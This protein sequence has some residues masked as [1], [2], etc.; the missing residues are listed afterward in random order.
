METTNAQEPLSLQDIFNAVWTGLKAQSWI[1]AVNPDT[2]ACKYLT[3]DGKKC[4]IGQLLTEDEACDLPGTFCYI[5]EAGRLP[6]RLSILT[7]DDLK[8]P[9]V[10]RPSQIGAVLQR[11]HDECVENIFNHDVS[12]YDVKTDSAKMEANF[13]TFAANHG[14]TIPGEDQPASTPA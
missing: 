14:L 2:G 11:L 13:R 12:K 7:E 3:V 8:T 10:G 6:A 1:A 5:N 9:Y 4:A